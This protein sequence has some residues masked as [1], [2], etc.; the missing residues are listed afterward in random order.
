MQSIVQILAVLDKEDIS[1]KT[2]KP[3]RITE[4]QCALIKDD[5]TVDVVGGLNLPGFR[6]GDASRPLPTPGLYTGQFAFI[7]SY[8]DGRLQPQLTGLTPLPVD[9]FKRSSK[10]QPAG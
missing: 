4:A 9:Y 8:Q 7:R 1:K 3:Y 10:S 5:G 6:P 2:G